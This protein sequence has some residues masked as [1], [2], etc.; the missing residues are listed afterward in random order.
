MPRK[1]KCYYCQ[2]H[3]IKP[4]G[5]IGMVRCNC[6]TKIVIRNTLDCKENTDWFHPGDL[7]EFDCNNYEER[8]Y[9]QHLVRE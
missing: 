6:G 9:Q 1:Y 8:N 3:K 7:A 2:H 4:D 5:R